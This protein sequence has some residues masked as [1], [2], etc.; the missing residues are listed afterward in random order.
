MDD[1]YCPVPVYYVWNVELRIQPVAGSIH[2]S[3]INVSFILSF[4]LQVDGTPVFFW[5]TD[6]TD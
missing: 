2:S 3:F 1:R 6:D 4:I 5:H